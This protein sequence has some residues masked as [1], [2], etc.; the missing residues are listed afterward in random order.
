MPLK[1]HGNYQAGPLK[2]GYTHV[3]AYPKPIY[4]IPPVLYPKDR[5]LN[6]PGVVYYGMDTSFVEHE[7]VLKQQDAQHSAH[8]SGW[9]PEGLP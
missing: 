8:P 2:A 1:P 4:Y 3:G 9:I 7:V 6:Q 5:N